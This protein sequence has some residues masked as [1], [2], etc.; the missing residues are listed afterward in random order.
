C[1]CL[2]LQ[3]LPLD[4]RQ[5]FFHKIEQRFTGDRSIRLRF[6]HR[7]NK[8][9]DERE[10][11]LTNYESVREGKLTPRLFG[12]A[13]L[14]EATILHGFG[15]QTYQESLPAFEPVEFKFVATATPDPNHYKKLIHYTGY[16]DVIDTGQALTHFF[17]RDNEKTG[18]LTLYPHM[19][20]QF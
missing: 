9:G 5:E 10:I 16:L 2:R 13:S 6:I 3:I 15:S 17:Q 19:K 14:D 4:V 11:Y 7:D 1:P 18:N 12:A 8:I 20:T